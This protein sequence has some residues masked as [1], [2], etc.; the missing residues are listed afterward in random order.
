MK[1]N[2]NE[3]IDTDTI[4]E[5][6]FFIVK[7]GRDADAIKASKELLNFCNSKQLEEP[8][9]DLLEDIREVLVKKGL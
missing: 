2:K 5:R 7:N 6:L 3:K 4:L 1:K 8:D 9:S